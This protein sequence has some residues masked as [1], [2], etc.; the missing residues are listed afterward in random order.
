MICNYYQLGNICKL[1]KNVKEILSFSCIESISAWLSAWAHLKSDPITNI[2][3]Y[4]S[5]AAI[6]PFCNYMLY[7]ACSDVTGTDAIF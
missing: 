1:Q 2:P 6:K 5:C 3:K 7:A 4:A